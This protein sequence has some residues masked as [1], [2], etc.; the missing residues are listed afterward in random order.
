MTASYTNVNG[1]R[2]VISLTSTTSGSNFSGISKP[3]TMRLS[4]LVSIVIPN[5]NSD[6][7]LS[8]TLESVLSSNY[9][10]FEIVVVDDGST[11]QSKL[12][13]EEWKI[14]FPGKISVFY[15]ANQGPSIAR[16]YGIHQASGR[17]IL[18]LDSDDKIHPDYIFKAVEKFEND[19]EIKVVYCE[20]KKFG[21]K[22][23]HWI[24]KPFSLNQLALD[25]MIFVSALFKKEDWKKTG[26]FDPRFSCG[27]EDWEFWIN[28]L[29]SGGK[30][31]KLSLVGF[32][33]R[34]RKCSRRKS[35]DSKGKQMT[36]NLLNSK[37]TEFF[38]SFLNGPLRNPRGLSRIIN[39]VWN[40]IFTNQP[41]LPAK[42]GK[43]DTS[44]SS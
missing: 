18:P 15:Q 28:M 44:L 42:H 11:D 26:G 43:I 17:Y 13:L 1:V 36:I 33:Y 7:F 9:P 6:Q 41:A 20:A 29:K 37:H 12:I 30:V 35:T 19:P 14:R 3:T 23:E 5:Y 39:P 8:E 31:E 27:W 32:Y 40:L 16:N 22:N 4:P 38:R 10:E 2:E 24:L 21:L 34:I 25:N